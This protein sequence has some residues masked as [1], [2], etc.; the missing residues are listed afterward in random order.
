MPLLLVERGKNSGQALCLR[1]GPT[2]AAVGRERGCALR[3][4]DAMASRRHFEVR[5]VFAAALAAVA[6]VSP[7]GTSLSR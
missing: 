4:S 1:P 2:A 5:F 6:A 7:V 3:L